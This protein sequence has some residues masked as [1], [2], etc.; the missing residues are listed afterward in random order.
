MAKKQVVVQLRPAKSKSKKSKR[1]KE[2]EKEEVSA[3]GKALRALGGIGGASAGTYLGFDPMVSTAAG[4]GLGAALSRW[5]GFGDYSVATNS[6]VQSAK[7]A[8]SIPSMHKTGQSIIVRHREYISEIRGAVNFTIRNQV[9]INP[10]LSTSFPWLAGLATQFSEYRIRG[11]VF[12]YIPS[13]G[14]AVSS[15]NAAI[16]TVMIQTS[17]RA[18]EPLPLNKQELLNEYW[19]NEARA[20]E[21]FCHPIECN[22]KENPFNV[23]YVRT[24]FL[25]TSENLLMYDLGRTTVAVS[26]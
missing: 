12:H 23:Q 18:S 10:G 4:S 9:Y 17:Y 19:S 6:L 1:V 7:A 8:G 21:E 22:P 25:P 16:G 5:L 13:S 11:M 14:Q 2:R 24:G 26:G 20:S 15:T 3:V